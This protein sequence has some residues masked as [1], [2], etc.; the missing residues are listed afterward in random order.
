MPKPA[1]VIDMLAPSAEDAEEAKPS[2]P[3]DPL[4]AASAK[5]DPETMIADIRAQLDQL[6]AMV[7]GLR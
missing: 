1:L 6:E 4:G 2:A 3:S 7:G 5:S